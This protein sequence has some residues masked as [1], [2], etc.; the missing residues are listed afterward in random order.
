MTGRLARP[1]A[2]LGIALATSMIAPAPRAQAQPEGADAPTPDQLFEAGVEA[3]RARRWDV[4]VD[5]FSRVYDLTGRAEV[6]LN[7]AAVE[8]QV[9][10]L[11]AAAATYRR[12]LRQ[13]SSSD[14]PSLR[15]EA[16]T[17]LAAVEVRIPR[18]SILVRG[19]I[20][21]DHRIEID[22]EELSRLAT[23]GGA[24]PIDPGAHI[25][26]MRRG[27]DE[28]ARAGFAVAEGDETEV[29]LAPRALDT[30]GRA[31]PG[32]R[33]AWLAPTLVGAALVALVTGLAIGLSARS[34]PDYVDGNVPPGYWE[35]R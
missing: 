6:L 34:E 7:L 26:V 28:V 5:A 13:T 20:G 29:T 9:G 22:G 12:F 15:V 21:A 1:L 8:L 11:V 33:R 23:V 18:V 25:V 14:D 19:Q 35:F 10:R 30:I 3:S 27:D 17:A 32:A 16:A 24:V 2:S 4:A 31:P